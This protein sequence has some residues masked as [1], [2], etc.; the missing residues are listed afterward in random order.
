MS[1]F[2]AINLIRSNFH[3]I[4]HCEGCFLLVVLFFFGSAH[5]E[6]RRTS[7]SHASLCVC[8][9]LNV[10]HSAFQ[11]GSLLQIFLS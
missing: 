10:R 1:M 7:V 5:E 11:G 4:L 3:D 6:C 8:G 9:R 2:G